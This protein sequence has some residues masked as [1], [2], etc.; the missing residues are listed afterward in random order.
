[1]SDDFLVSR[2]NKVG[3]A[4]LTQR[5]K[6]AGPAVNVIELFYGANLEN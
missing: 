3:D 1:M 4:S 5:Q 2:K 6:A